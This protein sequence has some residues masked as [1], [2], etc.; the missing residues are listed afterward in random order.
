MA[1][2]H[3]DRQHDER[4]RT[5]RVG[6]PELDADA[7]SQGQAADHEQTHA[8]GDGDV[9]GRR[10]GEP[11]VDRREVLGREADAGV[12]DLDQHP[13][14]GQG[15]TGDLDLGLRRG[16]GG[17]V[18]EQLGEE[19]HEVVDD[20]A[21]DLGRRHA[22]ELDALVLLHLGRGGTQDVDERHGPGPP[23][24]GLLTREDEEVFAVT[25]HTGGE[26]VEL[27][28]RGQLVRVGLAALELG[29]QGQLTLDEALAST[30]EV[31]EHRVDVATEQGLLGGESDGFL[32]HVVEG[33]GHLADLVPAVHTDGLHGRVDVLRVGLGQLL[34]ELGQTVVGDLLGGVLQT[35]QRAHHGAGHDEGADERDAE[36]QDDEG[37]VEDGFLLG[38]VAQLTGLLV[39]LREQGQLDLGHLFELDAVLVVPVAVARLL[40]LEGLG[41]VAE[42]PLGE[43]VRRGDVGVAAVEGLEQGGGVAGADGGEAA[44]GLFLVVQGGLAVL[45]VVGRHAR[46]AAVG[47]RG[48]DDRSLDGG[49][50]LGRGERRQRAGRGDHVAV[51]GGLGH[52]LG[53][54]QQRGD[55]RVVVADRLGDVGLVLVGVLPDRLD[56]VEL[57]GDVD[58]G[59]LDADHRR[60]VGLDLLGR[61]P[62]GVDGPVGLLPGRDDGVVLGVAVDDRA[63]RLVALLLKGVG[64]LGRLARHLGEQ[65]H[66]VELIHIVE[67]GVD[68]HRAQ[69][70]RRDD[71]EG[72][73]GHQT[74]ADAPVAQGYS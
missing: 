22:A 42:G 10:R 1:L 73:Q 9:H 64:E 62:E 55:Q 65:L 5:A 7:V 3:V 8:S 11:L 48:A 72:E 4:G 70:R 57:L 63:R 66:V 15:V 43:G 33:R 69:G 2:G 68:A 23:A 59:G 67:R 40:A 74:G 21:G 47:E 49:V 53:Q 16:E 31:G 34:D 71:G 26:V 30:R 60:V 36:D 45:V 25:A 28:Q 44:Q 58:K 37:T 6:R 61:V 54:R 27:E 38:L 19:V 29:D 51:A 39:H 56:L 50:L 14:V 52:V 12:V 41:V 20:A 32:V 35:T 17:G 13:P 24:A 46:A 18:L